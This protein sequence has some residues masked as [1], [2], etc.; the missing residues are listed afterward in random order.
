MNNTSLDLVCFHVLPMAWGV[1]QEWA[2]RHGHRVRLLVT[3]PGPSTRRNTTYQGVIGA[4]P[5]GQDILVTTR[6]RGRALPL[7]NELAPD[8]ILSFT[9][10]YRL[11]SE[12]TALPRLGAV[13]LHPTPL[14]LYR[15]PNPMRLM[16]DAYP[17]LGSTLHRTEE[18]FDTGVIYHQAVRPAPEDATPANVFAA[19]RETMVEALEVGVRR[20]VA[21]EPGLPQDHT[22]ATYAAEFDDADRILDWNLTRRLLQCRVTALSF[23]GHPGRGEIDGRLALIRTLTPLPGAAPEVPPGTVIAH[24]S[25]GAV[26]RVG[27]GLVR[28][29]TEPA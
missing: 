23:F 19:W 10:P 2:A 21:G 15:G 13:N 5:P 20:A 26:L 11:P 18:D 12:I 25:D 27:D 16:F 22:R 4:C 3:T 29:T 28:L 6:L 8:L 14:P 7:I 9:F 1:V 24:E 17:T